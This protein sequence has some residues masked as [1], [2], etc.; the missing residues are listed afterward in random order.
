MWLSATT[1][2]LVL[3]LAPDRILI[4]CSVSSKTGT[5]ALDDSDVTA[6]Q[7]SDKNG[8]FVTSARYRTL[9]RA[10]QILPSIEEERDLLVLE[11][12]ALR[13]AVDALTKT[14]SAAEDI[15]R[16]YRVAYLDSI[17]SHWYESPELWIGVGFTAG[18]I[19]VF[20]MVSALPD[21]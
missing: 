14:T 5:L 9:S 8:F 1:L 10:D 21:R 4:D 13:G 3:V 16:L 7:C 20:V 2:A 18:L 6:V 11:V 12:S 15:A 17:E 19:S